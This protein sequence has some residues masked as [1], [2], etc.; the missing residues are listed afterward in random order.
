[1]QGNVRH[2]DMYKPDSSGPGGWGRAIWGKARTSC[3]QFTRTFL[4]QNRWRAAGQRLLERTQ[5]GREPSVGKW[6]RR[7]QGQPPEKLRAL[8]RGCAGIKLPWTDG[9]PHHLLK[10]LPWLQSFELRN[11]SPLLI[12]LRRRSPAVPWEHRPP[13]PRPSDRDCVRVPRPPRPLCNQTR[14]AH[15]APALSSVARLCLGFPYA[16]CCSLGRRT[17]DGCCCLSASGLSPC[18]SFFF[19]LSLCNHEARRSPPPL[20]RAVARLAPQRNPPASP[21]RPSSR[22]NC[23]CTTQVPN[24]CHLCPAQKHV[25]HQEN[26]GRK[27]SG[28]ARWRR[29]DED[30]LAGH[31]GQ[32]K[33]P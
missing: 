24:R 5:G 17:L 13:A 22:P 4:P 21:T 7:W 16:T 14:P 28:R 33:S 12:L 32:G 27:P 23:R 31:Q 3:I 29:D 6:M 19:L 30:H 10:K 8:G 26:Q 25:F 11:S 1:M 2:R 20:R 15:A 9:T 18:F